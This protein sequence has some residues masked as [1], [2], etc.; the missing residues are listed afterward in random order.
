[1]KRNSRISPACIIRSLICTDSS[2]LDLDEDDAAIGALR[3][4][5]VPQTLGSAHVLGFAT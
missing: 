4:E 3:F 1:M 2:A 5:V